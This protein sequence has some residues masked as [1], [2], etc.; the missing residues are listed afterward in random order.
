MVHLPIC[1][2]EHHI[3]SLQGAKTCS[4]RPGDG[5][6]TASGCCGKPSALMSGT[7]LLGGVLCTWVP[8]QCL[9]PSLPVSSLSDPQGDLRAFLK[10]KERK[11]G[12]SPGMSEC[13]G[14][15]GCFYSFPAEFP[16]FQ[17]SLRTHW[18]L[19]ISLCS[20]SLDSVP[21][22]RSCLVHPGKSKWRME[23]WYP[24]YLRCPFS[25]AV[26]RNLKHLL[27]PCPLGAK[28]FH[29]GWWGWGSLGICRILE[30]MC[31]SS[32]QIK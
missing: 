3:Q 13:P 15:A 6:V 21:G 18:L 16:E 29:S 17:N 30:L 23:P 1:R 4:Q 8:T 2:T 5:P 14:N 22:K 12:S 9:A 7:H 25:R 24:P 27:I 20:R 26:G 19:S 11:T 10:K 31:A 28:A 32:A